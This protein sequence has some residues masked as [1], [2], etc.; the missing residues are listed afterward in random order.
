[1]IPIVDL[2]AGPGG[3]GEG[4]SAYTRNSAK[5]FRIALS[6][7]KEAS[8]HQ[9]LELRSFFRQ[10]PVGSIP[11][12]YYRFVQGKISRDILFER[13]PDQA[14]AA[15]QEA[16]CAELGSPDISRSELDERIERAVS[17]YSEWVLIG[18]PPCQAYSVAGRSRNKGVAGYRAEND[19]RHFLYREY[20]RILARHWP[21]VFVM[22][23]VKGILSS[24][25]KDSEIFHDMLDDLADPGGIIS[26]SSGGSQR[27]CRYRI[28]SLV[29]PSTLDMLGI[30]TDPPTD[31]IIESEKF[32]IP[33]ARHRVILLGVRDDIS[34][35][36][37]LLEPA[38]ERA[39]VSQVLQGLP[40]LRSG[41]SRTDDSG[42]AWRKA[43]QDI[44]REPWLDTITGKAGGEVLDL[45]IRVA[46]TLQVPEAD[47]GGEFIPFEAGADYRLDWYLDS[48]LGGV[49][50]SSTRL[51]IR[52]DL[53]RYLYS[54]CF[55]AVH[56]RSPR[57]SDFPEKLRPNHRN[58]SRSLNHDNFA[59]RFR[60]QLRD[61]PATTVV[62]HISKDGHYY[63]HYDP[64]QCRSMTVR[65]AARLQSF[66]DNYFFCGDRT[67]QYVQVGNAVPPLLAEQ[68]A[69]IVYGV[70]SRSADVSHGR[71]AYA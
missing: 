61:Q 51:H 20:L 53:Y 18:G 36:P 64:G 14:R 32:G 59:D 2:F 26:H 16:W 57:L 67:R 1:M 63:I 9:T 40:R 58:V 55:A 8:A 49:C 47:R 38:G 54:A 11:D 30:P 7:E 12:D 22:E 35:V 60:V 31:F 33:Q 65:E 46:E 13:H 41:L 34:T 25:I 52:E 29:K 21:P 4:F 24:R 39:T 44:L 3:L 62:S 66:P 5:P 23:N 56:K 10:F 28:Y 6:I 17:D 15:G 69:G 37:G 50:N 48:R 27:S 43:V 70:L 45:L 68:I 19:T 71:Y 42:E